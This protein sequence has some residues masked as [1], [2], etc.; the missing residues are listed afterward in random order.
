MRLRNHTKTPLR[1]IIRTNAETMVDYE[2]V[3][4]TAAKKLELPRLKTI[5]IGEKAEAE[6]DDA[7]WYQAWDVQGYVPTDIISEEEEHLNLMGSDNKPLMLIKKVAT[8]ERKKIY[9]Y[10]EMVKEGHIEITEKPKPKHTQKQ[11]VKAI[12]EALGTEFKPKDETH[13]IETFEKVIG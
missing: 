8:G 7:D 6:I 12:T 13:L 9:V 3:D 4:G 1:I 10:R 2:R 11:M 5:H